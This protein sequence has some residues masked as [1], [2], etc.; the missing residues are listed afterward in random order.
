[1][2]R[3]QPNSNIMEMETIDNLSSTKLSL[4]NEEEATNEGKQKKLCTGES[5]TLLI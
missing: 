5:K 3:T 2:A 1:M 4:W